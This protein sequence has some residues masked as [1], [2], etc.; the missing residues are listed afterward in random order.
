MRCAKTAKEHSD[1]VFQKHIRISGTLRSCIPETLPKFLEPCSFFAAGD[2]ACL[3]PAW[4]TLAHGS[5]KRTLGSGRGSQGC[6]CTWRRCDGG[7]LVENHKRVFGI[8]TPPQGLGSAGRHFNIIK[9]FAI[10]EGVQGLG[11]GGP[12]VREHGPKTS[13]RYNRGGGRLYR[14]PKG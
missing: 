3:D 10:D 11:G 5:Q 4:R 2:V 1:C 14:R 13:A 7:D 8:R 6:M 12:G 9:L